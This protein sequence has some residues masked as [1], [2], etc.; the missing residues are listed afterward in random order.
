MTL[1]RNAQCVFT[2]SFHACLFSGIFEKAF[3]AFERAEGKTNSRLVSLLKLFGVEERLLADEARCQ[4]SYIEQTT[5]KE[6]TAPTR[7]LDERIAESK[8]YLEVYLMRP[9]GQ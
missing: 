4:L 8:E 6:A 2:D 7:L 1:I 5:Q 9:L 3:W